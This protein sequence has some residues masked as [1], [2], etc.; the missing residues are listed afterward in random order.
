MINKLTSPEHL[1]IA[2]IIAKKLHDL[3]VDATLL[4][5]ISEGP[6]V[7]VYRV[8]PKGR[9]KVSNIEA[10]GSDFAVALGVEDVVVKRLAGDS[11]VSIFVPNKTRKNVS[12]SDVST[13]LW[14]QKEALHVPLAL[15]I[16]QTGSVCI[17]DL[18]E[19]PHLLIAGST[20]G[21]KSTLLNA[22]LTGLC[23]CKSAK[24][25][26]LVL[27]DTKGVE[28]QRFM[29]LGHL[30]MEP[31]NNVAETID[32][33]DWIIEQV[34]KRL[35]TFSLAGV[36]NINEYMAPM[37]RIVLVIDELADM[38]TDSRKQVEEKRT[39]AKIAAERLEFIVR[40]A[41]AAGTYVIAATQRPSVNVVAGSIKANFPARI[42]FKLPSRADSMTIIGENGAE[43]LLERGDMLYYSPKGTIQRIH[44][45]LVTEV[46]LD[47]AIEMAVRKG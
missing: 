25:I 5:F 4:D 34:E 6:V 26:Q 35:R 10:L 1:Q 37:P 28:F 46:E 3:G 9:T 2:G 32:Q 20:G 16:N 17:D 14:A 18:A 21:G 33:M 38:L 27:S 44:A 30:V 19:L 22:I 42:T 12:F 47:A 15:G 13:T 8:A 40:R 11:G 23:L 45:P 41:R 39:N 7:S 29:G 24:D 36:K 43:H 31:A